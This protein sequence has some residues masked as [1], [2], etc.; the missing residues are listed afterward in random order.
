MTISPPYDSRAVANYL[1]DFAEKRERVMTQLL[2]YKILYFSHGWY[3]AA[4]RK[5]LLAHD[6]EAWPHG[7]VIKVVRDE[8]RAFEGRP[9]TGRASRLDIFT[10]QRNVVES[11][12]APADAEFISRIFESYYQYGAW[13]LSD[14]THEHNSPW[15]KIWNSQKPVGRLALRLR[16]DDIQAHFDGLSSRLSIS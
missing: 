10:G 3:L 2:L 14:M 4:F 9:I 15:D 6:F 7:P 16:N 11:N 5:P 1:L 13:K 8:F 12:I